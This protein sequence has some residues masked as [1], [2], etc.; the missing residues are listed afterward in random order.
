MRGTIA[1]CDLRKCFAFLRPILVLYA[2]LLAGCT[3]RE[4][5]PA[6]PEV[7]QEAQGAA[8]EPAADPVVQ[9]RLANLRKSREN[10]RRIGEAFASMSGTFPPADLNGLS[11]RVNLLAYLGD[12]ALKLYR[13]FK[14][15]EPWDSPHNRKLL[16]LMPSV[17]A[18]VGDAKAE[19]GHTF[20]QVFVG[21]GAL[22]SSPESW[23]RPTDVRDGTSYT[24]AVVEAAEAVPWTKPQ[25]VRCDVLAKQPLPKLGGL[26]DGDANACLADGR[27]VFIPRTVPEKVVRA[28]ITRAGNEPLKFSQLGLTADEWGELLE[29]G[30]PRVA[31]EALLE[32]GPDAIAAARPALRRALREREPVAGLCAAD[33]LSRHQLDGK[34]AIPVL[35]A[36]VDYRDPHG[37]LSS[38]PG[39]P[40]FAARGLGRYGAEAVPAL[41][42]ALPSEAAV[43]GIA[44][45][46]PP[47]KDAVQRLVAMLDKEDAPGKEQKFF[48]AWVVHAL[49]RMGPAAAPVVPA[50]MRMLKEYTPVAKF[51]HGGVHLAP[52]VRTLG[53]IGPGAKDALPLLTWMASLP[54]DRL[55]GMPEDHIELA[56]AVIRIAP[57]DAQSLERL[58]EACKPAQPPRPAIEVAKAAFA[59]AQRDPKNAGHMQCL[60]RVAPGLRPV[61]RVS[62]KNSDSD[63]S[64]WFEYQDGVFIADVRRWLARFGPDAQAPAK[65]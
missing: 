2:L 31:H 40:C 5:A 4:P 46:G 58:N 20:Y 45:V 3:N 6:V 23:A 30:V 18:A 35:I 10:L 13:Q 48:R 8:Q 22:Y 65:Q 11:W 19:P 60:T 32:L 54:P 51:Q 36:N 39:R 55:T 34:E 9:Q 16:P 59:L 42:D 61:W 17:Y 27:V 29:H 63:M 49:G 41:I 43:Q 33:L 53:A 1:L 50:L 62:G 26:F 25:D 12:D 56:A 7:G 15:N 24:L 14:P 28:L 64:N 21:P 57:D 37:Y 38:W 44:E 52:V 47:A